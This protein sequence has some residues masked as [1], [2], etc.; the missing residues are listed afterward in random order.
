MFMISGDQI[1]DLNTRNKTSRIRDLMELIAGIFMGMGC[2][3]LL[4]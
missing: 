3:V 2:I 1:Q 4:S